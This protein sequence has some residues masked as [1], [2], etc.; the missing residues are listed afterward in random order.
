VREVVRAEA[1]KGFRELVADLGG[2]TAQILASA[3]VDDAALGNPDQYV[4]LRWLVNSIEVG[5]RRLNRPDFGLLSGLRASLSELGA[6]TVAAN[7]A[8]SGRMGWETVGRYIHVHNP[9]LLVAISPVPG[10]TCDL[11]SIDFRERTTRSTPQYL[12]RGVAIV[13]AGLRVLCG[14]HYRPSAV[15]FRNSR[16]SPIAVYRRIFGVETSFGM[17]SLGVVVEREILDARQPYRNSHLRTLAE[18]YLRGIGAGKSQF[19]QQ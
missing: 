9:A 14:Q 5:A 1:W 13:H 6:L 19:F 10:T 12:E 17:K 18:T 15:W 2:D 11:V 4:P 16:L 3:G 8:S 7:N